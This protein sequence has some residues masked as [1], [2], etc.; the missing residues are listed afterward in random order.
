M[1]HVSRTFVLRICSALL[2][3]GKAEYVLI[4]HDEICRFSHFNRSDF[5]FA[6]QSMSAVYARYPEEL[7]V[8][9]RL[10]RPA[11]AERNRATLGDDIS[12]S[13]RQSK[14]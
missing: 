13:H 11:W 7:W 3:I 6:S 4:N 8:K 12:A 10:T 5:G 2:A 9:C 1:N 14:F